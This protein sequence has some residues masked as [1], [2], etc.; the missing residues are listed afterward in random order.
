MFNRILSLCEKYDLPIQ[1]HTGIQTFNGNWLANANPLLLTS[2]IMRFPKVKFVLLHSG[3][4]YGG[5]IAALAKMFTNVYVDMT[6]TPLISPS[7]AVRYLQEYI[8]TVPQNK[9]MAF[10][11]DCNTVEGTYSAS[12]L[13]RDVVVQALVPMVR[14][15][16]LSEEEAIVLARKI[17][18]ENAIKIYKLDFLK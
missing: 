2:T 11:G 16:Y 5:E 3:Y 8:E 12:I 15:G 7:Y 10:G 14:N 13:A 18:R 4:P 1:I 6:W 9:I 17:L